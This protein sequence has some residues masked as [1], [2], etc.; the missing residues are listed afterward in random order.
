MGNKINLHS[1]ITGTGSY[2]PENVISGDAFLNSTFYDNGVALE[3]DI[4]EVINKFAEITEILERRYVD[5]DIVNSDIAAIAAQRAIDNAGIDKESLDHIIF[6]HN[7]GDVKNGSNRMDILPSLAAKVKQT[8]HILNPDCV[9]YDIIFGCPGWVQGA[10]QAN[11]LIQSGDAKR[12]M[13]IGAETLSRITDPHDRDSMIFSDGAAAVIFEAQESE[14][15]LGIIAHKTQ[16]FAVDY[17]SLLVMGKSNNPS[18]SNG[19]TYLKMNGRKLYEFAVINVPQVVK[20]AIDKAGIDIKDIKTV[21]IHQANGKMDTAIMKRL[22]KLYELDTV[23][24]NLVPMTISWLGNSS[25]A[26]IPTLLDL[27][28][29]EKVEGYKIKKGEYAVFAS[30]GAGMHINAFVYRF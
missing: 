6:C 12:V 28:L 1:V 21:F 26:T 13:V 17:A 5:K 18:E 9:A 3:K 29:K 10:I 24:E 25:V 27:V 7:F 2:I 16:T 22:F 23:P 4:N 8:L 14:N 30:V 19:N 11:Y 15:Q 20:K